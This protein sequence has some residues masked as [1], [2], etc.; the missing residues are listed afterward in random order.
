MSDTSPISGCS[1]I[2]ISQI[3]DI[4]LIHPMTTESTWNM[5]MLQGYARV[6]WTV[7]FGLI[8]S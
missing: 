4:V 8:N 7:L 5:S 3:L 6:C 2:P 1:S